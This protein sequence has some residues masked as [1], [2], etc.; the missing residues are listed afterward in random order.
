M[1]RKNFSR[2]KYQ[3]Q[4]EAVL[5]QWGSIPRKFFKELDEVKSAYRHAKQKDIF[6]ER[7]GVQSLKLLT[8]IKNQAGE[9]F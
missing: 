7:F 6:R 4:Q 3:R 2:R 1:L 5:R 8:Q 9:V